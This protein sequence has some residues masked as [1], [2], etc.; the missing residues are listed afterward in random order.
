M[1]GER[2]RV[3]PV[4]GEGIPD[5][6]ELRTLLGEEVAAAFEDLALDGHG[7]L[8]DIT[9][10]RIKRAGPPPDIRLVRVEDVGQVMGRRLI[11]VDP[12]EGPVYNHRAASEVFTDSEGQWVKIVEEW[13][14]FAWLAL[15]EGKRPPI[16]PRSKVYSLVNLWVDPTS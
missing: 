16:C 1:S 13:R 14:Y 9:D 2:A 3:V 10:W 4:P 6:D 8:R 12:D 15:P 11:Y 5:D 7:T